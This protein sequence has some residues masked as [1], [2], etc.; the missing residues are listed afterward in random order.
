[1]I[2]VKTYSDVSIKKLLK[3][4]VRLFFLLFALWHSACSSLSVTNAIPEIQSPVHQGRK[5]YGFSFLA[6]AGKE[7]TL[8]DD[9]SARPPDLSA[10]QLEVLNKFVSR[11]AI[12]YYP[13]SRLSL[14]FGLQNSSALLFDMKISLLN[15]LIDDPPP[16]TIY[17]SF[18]LQSTYEINKKSG[19]QSGFGG[20]VGY[21]WTAKTE[22]LTGTAGISVGYQT[23]KKI[24][25]FVGFNYQYVQTTGKIDQEAGSGNAGGSYQLRTQ[26]GSTRVYGIGFDWKPKYEFFITPQIDYYEFSWGKNEIKEAVGSIKLTYVPVQ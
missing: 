16:G 10:K 3:L 19:S 1:M 21:P 7:L 14:E 6:T 22:N 15:G 25:P 20:P 23:R 2:K 18:N 5:S 12:H 17:A 11:Q 9:A 13:A 26:M 8:I 24:V 4:K